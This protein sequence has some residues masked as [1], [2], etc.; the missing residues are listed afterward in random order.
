LLPTDLSTAMAPSQAPDNPETRS[1]EATV[2]DGG[3]EVVLSETF[4][5][6][7]FGGGDGGSPTVAQAGGLD[8][9][10][11]TVVDFLREA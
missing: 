10:G 9:D 5:L 8:A 7:V 11:E 2:E 1:F 3:S 4:L 6:R